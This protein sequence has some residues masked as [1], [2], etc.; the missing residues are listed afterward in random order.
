MTPKFYTAWLGNEPIPLYDFIDLL[1]IDE[2]GQVSPEVAGATFALAKKALIVGDI[3]QIEPVWN[4]SRAVDLY[5]I[6]KSNLAATIE[7][8]ERLITDKYIG[9]SNGSVMHIA[10]RGSKYQ[11]FAEARGMYL[12]EHRRCVPEIISYCNRL[13]YKGRLIPKRGR[14]VN[15]A[16]PHMG[17]AHVRGYMEKIGGS[18]RNQIEAD[19]ITSWIIDNQ[20]NLENMYPGHKLK[21]IVAVVTPFAQ[22]RQLIQT[23]L[24]RAKIENLTVGTV[25]AL[26]GAERPIVIFSPVYD[27]SKESG[28]FFDNG[29]NMLNVAVS[30]AKDSFL[31]FGDMQIFDVNS[32]L[33]SGILAQYLF[34]DEGNEIKNIKIPSH[35][36]SHRGDAVRHV[37]ELEEHRRILKECILAARK[38]IHI[39]SPFLSSEAIVADS[40]QELFEE[41]VRKGTKVTVYTDKQL[42]EQNGKQKMAFVKAKEILQES[43]V[44]LV[45]ANRFHNKTLWIDDSLLIE[46]SFNWLSARRRP[47]DPWCRYETSLVYQGDGVEVMI[48][49]IYTDLQ[50]RVTLL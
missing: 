15:H 14:K 2:A 45:M 44:N 3:F 35:T 13:A 46:G 48:Q 21:D 31:V 10:Q 27:S 20:T 12:T 9:A 16:L 30:R 39:V 5:N 4:I 23:A 6:V 22:Q 8:A 50:K 26:Q 41:A 17:Y 49:Q 32:S 28:Y 47:D 19:V 38:E 11:K 7:E 34:A 18:Y 25:H 42:N 40:L 36:L 24:K 43:G 37:R 29:I 33:P 1:I